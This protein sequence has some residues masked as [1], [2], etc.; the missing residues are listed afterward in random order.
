MIAI[1]GKQLLLESSWQRRRPLTLVVLLSWP[2]TL[3]TPVDL[4]AQPSQPCLLCTPLSY[5]A[6]WFVECVCAVKLVVMEWP[7]ST[8][9]QSHKYSLTTY[10]CTNMNF[11]L[12]R[13]SVRVFSMLALQF[14]HITIVLCNYRHC[15]LINNS[16]SNHFNSLAYPWYKS[17]HD[18]LKQPSIQLTIR[19]AP[20]FGK[21]YLASSWSWLMLQ[22]VLM[23]STQKSFW[24]HHLS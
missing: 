17:C 14:G 21:L 10:H 11:A 7:N 15:L 23:W 1:L 19:Q 9:P 6:K 12:W 4:F 24:T 22:K 2:E 8:P 3:I 20:P 18:S 16:Y 5:L 13:P